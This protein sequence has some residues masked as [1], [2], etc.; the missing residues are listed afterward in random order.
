M[1]RIAAPFLTKG[2]SAKLR[3][4]QH[5]YFSFEGISAKLS[6]LDAHPYK[7]DFFVNNALR[8]VMTSLGYVHSAR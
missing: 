4:S 5:H 7:G 1:V 3:Y 2:R 6:M 8:R